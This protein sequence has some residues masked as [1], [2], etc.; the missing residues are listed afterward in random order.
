MGIVWI[1]SAI[2]DGDGGEN[3]IVSLAATLVSLVTVIVSYFTNKENLKSTSRNLTSA[4][5]IDFKI[6]VW[7]EIIDQCEELVTVTNAEHLE[8]CANITIAGKTNEVS[9]EEILSK[10]NSNCEHIHSLMFKLC[11]NIRALD[12][13]SDTLL[14]EIRTY[15][16]NVIELYRNMQEFYLDSNA[17]REQYKQI[18]AGVNE[19]TTKGVEFSHNMQDYISLLQDKLFSAANEANRSILDKIFNKNKKAKKKT[20]GDK[21]DGNS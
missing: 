10:L 13:D 18:V 19:Y 21:K 7:H 2:K 9:D 12:N 15:A 17:T 4:R 14:E 5:D 3:W 6:K 11:L 20:K 8:Q 1:L 16:R